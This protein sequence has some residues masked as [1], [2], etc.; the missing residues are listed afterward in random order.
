MKKNKTPPDYL[1]WNTSLEGQ[2]GKVT[3]KW[4]G[5]ELQPQSLMTIRGI[6]IYEP[7]VNANV[8]RPY[9]TGDW[10]IM[11]FHHPARLDQQQNTASVPANTLMIWPT[12]TKQFFSWATKPGVELHS[13]MHVEG[14]WVGLQIDD[15]L[16]PVNTPLTLSDD[17]IMLS[18]LQSM[19]DEMVNPS[20]HDPIILQNLFQNWAR[21]IAKQLDT[22]NPIMKIPTGFLAVKHY[23]DQHFNEP[24]VLDDLAGLAGVSR[25]YLC[26]QFKFF[27]DTNISQYVI[28]K[29]MAIAQRLLF[30]AQM[31]LGSIAVEVGYPDIYQFSKQF[32][33]TFG[34]SPSKYRA[35]QQNQSID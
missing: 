4:F 22:K 7:M 33:K 11:L 30:N 1:R 19:M 25:S 23:L 12:G 13:W 17:S 9:G 27:F 16:L 29:R 31:R 14:T 21:S 6:G 24:I 5:D 34:V 18:H 20:Q 10:L 32:K 26:H 35:Q 2:Q 3:R 28:R 15:N 8:D